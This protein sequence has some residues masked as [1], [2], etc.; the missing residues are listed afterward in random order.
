MKP[1]P[2][3]MRLTTCH[4]LQHM[5]DALCPQEPSPSSHSHRRP[6]PG[7]KPDVLDDVDGLYAQ[8]DGIRLLKCLTWG[9][10]QTIALRILGGWSRNLPDSERVSPAPRQHTQHTSG[11]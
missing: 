8:R 6:W 5:V 11:D 9:E 2:L 7:Q 10:S 4:R 3:G 1:T